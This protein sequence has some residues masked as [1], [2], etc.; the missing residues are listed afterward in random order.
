MS[1]RTDRTIV[2]LIRLEDTGRETLGCLT[3]NGR[4]TCWCIERPWLDNQRKVSCIPCGSYVCRKREEWHLAAKFGYCYEVLDVPE[5]TDILFHPANTSEELHG[6]IA[7]GMMLGEIARQRAVLR[8][9]DGFYE[10][11]KSLEAVLEFDLA[12]IKV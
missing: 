9:A 11:K 8:S 3:V 4:L 7:P 1:L 5:R 6:C 2:R 10:F 12:V